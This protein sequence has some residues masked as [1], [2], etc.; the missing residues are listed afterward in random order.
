MKRLF[1]ALGMMAALVAPQAVQADKY[2][3]GVDAARK[4]MNAL[5]DK[6]LAGDR[7]ALTQLDQA[8]QACRNDMSC[9]PADPRWLPAGAAAS[10][11]GWLYWTKEAL[12][13]DRKNYGMYM[14]AEA[15]RM[16][17]P[18]GA[19]QAGNCI[20]ESCLPPDLE[21]SY[22]KDL[23]AFSPNK[24]W[25]GG[26]Y[27]RFSAASEIY[28]KGAAEGLVAAAVAAAKA[29]NEILKQDLISVKYSAWEDQTIADY[30]HRRKIV[31]VSKLGLQHDPSDQ[32][33]TS[34]TQLVTGY[35]P[36]LPGLKEAADIARARKQTQGAGAPAA[37]T[38]SAAP[39][40]GAN[41]EADKA[42][43]RDCIREREELGDWLNELRSWKRDL[44]AWDRKIKESSRDLQVAGGSTAD[45]NQHNADVD[46]YNAEGRDY[47][48]EK[49][50]H[51]RA[52]DA[53][54]ARCK[55]SFNRAAID[56]VCVGGNA[57]S[58]FCRGFR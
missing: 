22:F 54:E 16:G 37:Q 1:L 53:H 33:R 5:G 55:G 46:A 32:E 17:A 26:K 11:L 18:A 6:A 21:K 2:P 9:T 52:A 48:A 15:A 49:R 19:Y 34:L 39:S 24:P 47:S 30:E 44:N 3:D 43:A 28:R 20:E 40:R 51:D 45:Y 14:Y 35:E 23:F 10:N 4:E 42:R 50:K 27:E 57:N 8:Y 25:D 36:Q 41:Y 58:R 56:E 12:G 38:A 29:E 13:A 7:S 31:E